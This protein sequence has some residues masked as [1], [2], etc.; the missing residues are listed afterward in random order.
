MMDFC[1]NALLYLCI[2]HGIMNTSANKL[3][4]SMPYKDGEAE[5]AGG[6]FGFG[7]GS[8][9]S[10]STIAGGSHFKQTYL[11]FQVAFAAKSATLVSGAVAGLLVVLAIITLDSI[12]IDD[13]LS[14][15]PVHG[16]CGMRVGITTGITALPSTQRDL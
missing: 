6:I 8:D 11:L 7:I 5:K 14:A 2:G 12:G 10:T 13:P 4:W 1:F 9:G 15:F 3:L 16:V